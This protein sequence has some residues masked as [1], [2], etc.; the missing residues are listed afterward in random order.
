MKVWCVF[1]DLKILDT[2]IES[3]P[4]IQKTYE[5]NIGDDFKF[6]LNKVSSDNL[7]ERLNNIINDI[8]LQGKKLA[9]HMD[10]KDMKIYRSLISDFMQQIVANSHEFKRQN[11]LDKRGRHRV[12]GIVKLV[13]KELDML[14]QEL[15]KNEKNQIYILD[16]TGEILG[17]LL[18]LIV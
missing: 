17:L 16:K 12:Y 18:D 10:I 13:N 3:L 5:K 2:K 8:S 11:F 14:A 15:I 9:K 4:N 7:L 6:T 1:M